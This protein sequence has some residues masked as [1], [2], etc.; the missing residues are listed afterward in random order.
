M[1]Y[2]I[3]TKSPDCKGYAVQKPTGEV[4]GCHERRSDAV[5][6]I[7]ALYINV[8]D[9]VAKATEQDLVKLHEEFHKKYA[10]PD[11]DIVIESHHWLSHGLKK[12][13]IRLPSEP[14]WEAAIALS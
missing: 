1:P 11:N 6:H 8:P 4:V 10:S 13:G 5:A 9:A 14:D 3:S 7:R 12:L 2:E